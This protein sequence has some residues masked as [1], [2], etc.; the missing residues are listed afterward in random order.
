MQSISSSVS[1]DNVPVAPPPPQNNLS[2]P[3]VETPAV[4]VAG[5]PVP[6]PPPIQDEFDEPKC[7]VLYDFEGKHPFR[8]ILCSSMITC[9]R[10]P[11]LKR[12]LVD[13]FY[14]EHAV[15]NILIKFILICV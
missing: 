5:P 4:E 11:G 6:P 1:N 7:T 3:T 13:S 15:E 2:Q 9:E 10:I 14:L 12:Y 8:R